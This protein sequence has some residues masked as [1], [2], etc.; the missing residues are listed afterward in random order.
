VK[1]ERWI[2]QEAEK[3]GPILE[4]A[5]SILVEAGLPATMIEIASGPS[6]GV[7]DVGS[8]CLRATRDRRCGTIVVG[9][10]SLSWFRELFHRHHCHDLVRQ[11][12][13]FTVWVVE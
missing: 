1:Q 7:I 8:D 9:R 10:S 6:Y 5:A 3:E 11:A 12:R 2:E 13:G 4:R